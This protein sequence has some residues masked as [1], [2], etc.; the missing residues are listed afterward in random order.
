MAS[1]MIST[2]LRPT[3]MDFLLTITLT[4]H[5]DGTFTTV[6]LD[7]GDMA[8]IKNW[9]LSE[10]YVGPGTPQPTNGTN[11]EV[12]HGFFGDADIFEQ[13]LSGLSNTTFIRYP[14]RITDAYIRDNL[15]I[16]WTG[17]SVNAAKMILYLLLRR[18]SE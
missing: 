6:L 16:K 8:R 9:L 14:V 12:Q 11:I 3:Q 2:Y 18:G 4:A 17:N 1:S 15:K 13:G 7:S 5:T 10:A